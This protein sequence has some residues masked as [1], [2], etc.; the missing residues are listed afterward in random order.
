V[1]RD[2]P[3][4]SGVV[5]RVPLVAT[6]DVRVLIKKG[7]EKKVQI[8]INVPDRVPAPVKAGQVV[9]E[10]VVKF[11]GAEV[12]KT[13]AAAAQDVAQASLWKRWWPFCL[14][15][16]TKP[17]GIPIAT[18]PCDHNHDKPELLSGVTGDGLRRD[19]PTD[20]E[21]GGEVPGGDG[22]AGWP[23]TNAVSR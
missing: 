7:E 10:I 20:L 19:Q 22:P 1:G 12:G 14:K 11:D 18:C 8:E 2:A 15:S 23:G 6:G 21:H 13:S 17:G 3:V 4:K 16:F 5:E 9:G